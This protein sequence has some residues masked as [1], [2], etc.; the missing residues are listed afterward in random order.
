MDKI[1]V[2]TFFN[3]RAPE[4]DDELIRNDGVIN[5]ILDIA[6]VNENSSVLDVACGTGVLFD[7]YLKRKVSSIDAID[8][9]DEMVKSA[10]VKYPGI[11]V[12]C[13][14]A[15]EYCF[16]KAFDCI[17][18]YNAFPHFINERK[19][20]E[21][22]TRFLKKGGRLTVAHGMSREAILECHSGKASHISKELPPINSLA[23]IVRDFVEVDVTIS[24]DEMYVVSG[25]EK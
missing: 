14:D 3:E 13:G 24:N 22:L 21:N 23:Q 4:W 17:V 5:T 9:S 7:D 12:I 10:K 11:N 16:N 18:I 8:I 6:G 1:S 25:F 19:L 20:F 2:I 15:E